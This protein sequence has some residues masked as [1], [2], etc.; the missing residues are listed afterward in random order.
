M[1][2]GRVVEEIAAGGLADARHPYTLGLL[3]CL[4]K[5][6]DARHPLPTLD[7]QPEWAL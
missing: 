6:G 1:Y 5:L 2:A 7:R 4:P 3:N